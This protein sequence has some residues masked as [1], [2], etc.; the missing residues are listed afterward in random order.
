[1]AKVKI[2]AANAN[3]ERRKHKLLEILSKNKIFARKIHTVNDGFIAITEEREQDKI[4]NNKTDDEMKK[5]G[6]YPQIPLELKAKRSV[7][8][9]RVDS[10]TFDKEEE[11][12]KTEI[13][14][15]NEWVGRITQLNK[16]PN[17]NIIKITFDET[18]KATR[19]TEHGLLA[20][21]MRLSH[22][23][24]K[25]DTYY[26]IITC[27]KCY[28]MEEHTTNKCKKSNS[29][30]I[31][32]N[33]SLEGHIWKECREEKKKHVYHAEENTEQWK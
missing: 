2:K 16:F 5:E 7:L 31:C 12:I 29:Y 32:S 25:I 33:C 10:H 14:K 23:D 21:S 27:Y 24:I 15:E 22:H 6:F 17:I 4:F 19:A 3:D 11:A 26:N 20:F 1:M 18:N 30:K 13:E 9:F 8:V 28:T